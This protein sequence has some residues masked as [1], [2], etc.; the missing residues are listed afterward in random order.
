[1]RVQSWRDMVLS[2]YDPALDNYYSLNAIKGELGMVVPVWFP[3][4][5]PGSSA[6]RIL[7]TA[8][9]DCTICVHPSRLLVVVDGSRVGLSAAESIR[10]GSPDFEILFFEENRGKGAAVA[11]GMES[12]L[13]MES[14]GLIAVR[15]CD[16]DHFIGDLPHLFRIAKQ[17]IGENTNELVGVIGRR[18]DLHRPLGFVRGEYELILDRLILEGLKFRLA[19][20]GMVLDCRYFAPYSDLPDFQSGYKVYS[21]A[22]ARLI[23]DAMSNRKD[24]FPDFDVMR[25]GCEIVPIVEI[26]LAGGILGE[27]GRIAYEA[28][29]QTAYGGER[30]V[31]FYGRKA[32]WLL[33]RLGIA[34]PLSKLLLDRAIVRSS[35]YKDAAGEKELMSFRDFVLRGEGGEPPRLSAYC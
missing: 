19:R 15:D 6:E 10:K 22:S 25:Y 3:E 17:I 26:V 4:D 12:L 14:V 29:P 2:G 35:L 16:G 32:M 34:P 1:M 5:T 18:A 20:E 23:V 11:S 13:G 9:E 24:V 8:L 33:E 27:V 7:R 21:R 31:E 28:Q 30:R